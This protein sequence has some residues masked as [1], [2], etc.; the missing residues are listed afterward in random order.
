MKVDEGTT[1]FTIFKESKKVRGDEV[2]PK[3]NKEQ[4]RL[5]LWVN[6]LASLWV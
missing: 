5:I 6:K 4:P 2:D 1:H 3:K